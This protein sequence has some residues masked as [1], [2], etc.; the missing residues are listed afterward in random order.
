MVNV[1]GD[2]APPWSGFPDAETAGVVTSDEK[3]TTMI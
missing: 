1:S 2:P 3:L